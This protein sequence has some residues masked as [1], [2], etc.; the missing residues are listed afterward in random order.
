MDN[1]NTDE[2]SSEIRE[3]FEKSLHTIGDIHQ[4]SGKAAT[5]NDDP[6]E[7]LLHA[8]AGLIL[9]AAEYGRIMSFDYVKETPLLQLQQENTSFYRELFSE[10]Y[11]SSYANPS[12]CRKIFGPDFG[13]LYSFFYS[14]FRPYYSTACSHK[15]YTMALMNRFFIAVYTR[16]KEGKPSP[17]ELIDLFREDAKT[18]RNVF[19]VRNFR[20]RFEPGFG[21]TNQIF[22]HADVF[23]E[24]TLFLYGDYIS[25]YDLTFARFLKKYPADKLKVLAKVIR[26]AYELGFTVGQKKI[27]AE[28]TAQI[29][30]KPGQEILV[31]YLMEELQPTFL[32]IPMLHRPQQPNRQYHYDHSFDTS[33]FFDSDFVSFMN[34]TTE[35]AAEECK[36]YMSKFSGELMLTMQDF[37]APPFTPVQK[38]GRLE[39]S[40]EQNVLRQQLVA[41]QTEIRER[42][43]Q[44][45][46]TSFTVI[47]FPT[48]EIGP[49]FE[50]IFADILEVNMLDSYKYLGIQQNLID[51]LDRGTAVHMKGR[52]GNDTDII[53]QFPPLA[54][55]DSHTNFING[56]AEVNIPVGE[57]F[58][59]PQLKGSTGTLHCPEF[60]EEGIQ[61]ENLRI[62]FEDG[63]VTDYSCTNFDDPQQN[64][65]LIKEKL[66]MNRDVLPMGEFAIGT[67]TLAYAISKKYDIEKIMPPLI[68][69][70]MGPHI[71]VGDTCF[72]FQEDAMFINPYNNKIVVAKENEK[73]KLRKTD[74][75]K[76]YVHLHMDIILPFEALSFITVL[77][78]DGSKVDL[79]RQ[80]RFV[81]PGTEELN[82]PLDSI[83]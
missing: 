9:R 7:S 50:E 23:D 54:N 2:Q 48:P 46:N 65:K 22:D 8:T 4:E 30:Y 77:N 73:S 29:M 74:M 33:L 14:K 17:G 75:Q 59:T 72:Y 41:M 43:I 15:F 61:F 81:V 42:Y 60:F 62:H 20:S 24:R 55:P 56:V 83:K 69:E 66:F 58:T 49:R 57:V 11:E 5:N 19:I 34:R 6:V 79:I 71:A 1:K 39:Y 10:N 25:E 27:K 52:E 18:G 70:K 3:K 38:E 80:G 16:I 37:G 47:A 45:E 28:S 78:A 21:Y 64:R 36:E 67:N 76:A 63:Y 13:S 44:R 32:P 40:R 26:D 31:A 53:V 82:I 12:Y 35:A 68:S 51:I